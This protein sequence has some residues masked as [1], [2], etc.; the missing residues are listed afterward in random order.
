MTTTWRLR[1]HDPDL[2]GR[3]ARDAQLPPLIAQ[4]LLNRRISDPARARDFIDCR[5]H[6]LHDPETLPGVAEAADRISRA[7]AD[8]RKI[9]IYGDYDVDGVCGTSILWSLLKLAGCADVEYYIPHRVDEGYGLNAEALKHLATERGASLVVSVDCGITAVKEARLAKELGLELIITDHH[10]LAD[11]L[12]DAAALVHPR[13]PGSQYPFPEL[14]GCGVAFKLAWQ[15]AKGFGDG[16]KASPRLRDFLVESMGLVA[17]AT[18]ADLVPLSDENR[19]FVR[20]GLSGIETGPSVGLQALMRVSN[21]LGK[22]LST[23]TVGF[24][25]GPRINAAGRMERAMMAVELLTT[26]DAARAENLAEELDRCNKQRQ[27]IEH[28]IVAQAKRMHEDRSDYADRG[29]IV[30]GHQEWHPGVIGI[31]ASRL[32]DQ[33]HRPAIVASLGPD[34]AQGSGRSVPGFDLYRAI[35]ACSDRLIGF[36]GHKAA[37]GLK[38]SPADFDDFAARFDDHCRG[39]LTPEQREKT[40]DI[41]AEVRLGMLNTA[42]VDRIE[43]LE[44]YG[45]GNPRPI[46]VASGLTLAAD[47]RL[48]GERKNHVQLRLSQ[49]PATLKAVAWNMADRVKGLSAGTP[50]SVAFYPNINEWNGRRE[51]QLEIKDLKTAGEEPGWVGTAALEDAAVGA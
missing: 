41:D 26:H 29:A 5:R 11:D 13:L 34:L 39:A 31:V 9:V 7:I 6:H 45:I 30:L 51:V 20:Y 23:G 17:M 27:E 42:L 33:Y 22:K 49:G 48:C 40:L 25:L 47:P 46:F 43:S 3:L 19:V 12:P 50:L 35:Q 15:V 4:I 38:M 21:A 2:V 1:P 18:I 37:A 44:P 8:R 14:C 10:T 36:G 16:K 24:G 32:V 28:S